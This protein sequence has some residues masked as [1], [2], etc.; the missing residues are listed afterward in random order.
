MHHDATSGP[1]GDVL[2]LGQTGGRPVA[3]AAGPAWFP[4]A[5][6]PQGGC[7]QPFPPFPSG[8]LPGEDNLAPAVF[9]PSQHVATLKNSRT[10]LSFT[11]RRTNFTR[12]QP[13]NTRRHRN[14]TR[15]C[16]NFTQR[17][18]KNTRSRTKNPQR[19]LNI[20]WSRQDKRTPSA[21]S[22]QETSAGTQQ[23]PFNGKLLPEQTGE[24]PEVGIHPS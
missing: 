7:A 13:K 2:C 23:N 12:R 6:P 8:N 24:T 11:Q 19:R 20:A 5:E 4:P 10:R 9:K 16:L 14:F 18:L 17:R 1:L 22:R 15:G 3:H 21:F